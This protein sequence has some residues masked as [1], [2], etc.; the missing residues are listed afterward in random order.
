[1]RIMTMVLAAAAGALLLTGCGGTTPQANLPQLAII[2]HTPCVTVDAGRDGVL[3][4]LATAGYRDGETV[5]I[6]QYDAQ[7]DM[8]MLDSIC[9]QVVSG[10]YAVAVTLSTP[11][12]QAMA[13]ANRDGRI[14]Q[15]FGLVTDPFGAGVGLDRTRPRQ[16]PGHLVGIGTFEPVAE[17]FRLAKQVNPGLGSVGVVFNA[18]E[19]CSRTCVEQARQVCAGLGISLEEIAVENAAGVGEAVQALLQRGVQ[20]FWTAGDNTVDNAFPAYAAMANRQGIP[21]FSSNLEHIQ[22]GAA[23]CLGADYHAVGK[24]VGAM[25]AGVLR[26]PQSA[27]GIAIENVVPQRLAVNAPLFTGFSPAWQA[28]LP[29]LQAK[30]PPPVAP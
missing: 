17:G 1:M 26:N 21:V 10:D 11:C 18:G 28:A 16:H 15:V 30:L 5:Q 29:A 23:F 2:Q 4:A 7:G 25:A 22:D 27:A 9:R 13:N 6:T 24:L 8:G 12:L 20:A 19:D 3:A 14:I